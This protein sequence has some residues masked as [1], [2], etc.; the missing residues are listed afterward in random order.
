MKK[1]LLFAAL[2]LT[3]INSQ[4]SAG[5]LPAF[6]FS[7]SA[8]AQTTYR[9]DSIPVGWT[10]T[11]NGIS[12]PVISYG[13]N[14]SQLGYVNAAAGATIGV[15]P[16]AA[17]QVCGVAV[18]KR[19]FVNG[20]E[21][22]AMNDS[23]LFA[24]TNI[25]AN[26]EHQIG[27]YYAWGETTP[28]TNFTWDNYAFGNIPNGTCDR[29]NGNDY[30]VLLPGDDAARAS[31]SAPWRTP[32]TDEWFYSLFNTSFTHT[33]V[34]NYKG[35]GV[36]GLL[37]TCNGG[38]Y[39]GN[40][41]FLPATGAKANTSLD[42]PDEGIY[43]TASL[44]PFDVDYSCYDEA[45]A[46]SFYTNGTDLGSYI[47]TH[48]ER[49]MG[50]PVRAF[51]VDE[52]LA[53]QS[54]TSVAYAGNN[55]WN[56]TMP[57]DGAILRGTE[58]KDP[59]LTWS[60]A[61]ATVYRCPTSNLGSLPRLSAYATSIDLHFGSSDTNVATVNSAGM[62][63]FKDAGTTS[64]YVVHYRNAG[65]GYAYDSAAF[66]L[67]VV[68]L[69]T[70]R[71]V[72]S[73][74][75]RGSVELIAPADSVVSF[76]YGYYWIVPGTKVVVKATPN[77]RCYLSSWSDGTAVNTTGTDT[78][79]VR[80]SMTI[81]A[82]FAAD[83]HQVSVAPNDPTMG[84]AVVTHDGNSYSS[85]TV[86][87]GDSV[88]LVATPVP[89]H[90]FVGWSNGATSDTLVIV[91]TG[92][93]SL[94]AMF[95]KAVP[96]RGDTTVVAYDSLNWNGTTYTESGF[97]YDTLTAAAANGCDSIVTSHLII[98]PPYTLEPRLDSIPIS[99]TVSV[100]GTPVNITPYDA[101]SMLGYVD[102]SEG[103]TVTVVPDDTVGV[104][105]VKVR[106]RIFVNGH[107][108]IAMT[109]SLLFALTNIGADSAHQIGNYYAWGE[110]TPKSTFTWNNYRF[111]N[112]LSGTCTR[113]VGT[114]TLT[115]LPED[116]AAR[117]NWGEP[118]RMPTVDDWNQIFDP[119]WWVYDWERDSNYR[120]SGVM[121]FVCTSRQGDF[122]GNNFFLPASGIYRNNLTGVNDTGACWTASIIDT[123][124]RASQG[125]FAFPVYGY[126]NVDRCIG[127]P[128][129]PVIKSDSLVRLTLHPVEY[130]GN[131]SW[132]FTMPQY[133]VVVNPA[134]CKH[135]GLTWMPTGVT[136]YEGR[137]WI[138]PVL[139]NPAG[140]AVRYGSLNPQV[141][142]IDDT[143][144][145]TLH[146]L[147]SATLY[148]VHYRNSGDGYG[149]D[150][151][152][153][154]LR[155]VPI[156]T[157]TLMASP[158]TNGTVALIEDIF[159][160]GDTIYLDTLTGDYTVK[161][162]DVLT[163]RLSG[164]YQIFADGDLDMMLSGV[165]IDYADADSSY[166]RP[167]LSGDGDVTIY[168]AEGTENYVRG[169]H[170]R[171][172][173]E[174]PFEDQRWQYSGNPG[175]YVDGMLT[176]KGT[177]SLTAVGNGYQAAGIQV[178]Y[179]NDVNLVIE[180]G[181]ITAIGGEK[182]PGIGDAHFLPVGKMIINGGHVVALGG[183][184]GAGIGGGSEAVIGHIMINGGSVLA[185]GG[186]L[187]DGIGVSRYSYYSYCDAV[188]I[189]G[190]ATKVTA[191]AG[192]RN[193]EYYYH[194]SEPTAIML[195][196]R[197]YNSY[198][199]DTVLYDTVVVAGDTLFVTDSLFTY[200]GDGSG[201]L[202]HAAPLQLNDGRYAVARGAEVVAKGMPNE[203]YHVSGW[204]DGTLP[205]SGLDTIDI[206]T[207]KTV[208]VFFEINQ[209]RLDSI[210]AGWTV[211]ADSLPVPVTPYDNINGSMGYVLV[212]ETS[213]VSIMP[214]HPTWVDTL[215]LAVN[216]NG[217]AYVDMGDGLL[218]ATCN[219]GADS[220]YHNGDYY[221]WGELETQYDTLIPLRWKPGIEYYNGYRWPHYRWSSSGGRATRYKGK[222]Y[223]TLRPE[224]DVA[225]H[226][227]GFDW[228]IPT[229]GEWEALSD[230]RN[231]NWSWT[232]NYN[233]TGVSGMVVTSKLEGYQG[234]SI[235]LPSSDSDLLS[236]LNN[237]AGNH[238]FYWSSTL[239]TLPMNHRWDNAGVLYISPEGVK[240]TFALRC[241]G[242]SVRPVVLKPDMATRGT[243]GSWNFT[244]SSIDVHLNVV[245]HQ[246]Y[247]TRVVV[248]D[249]AMGSAQVTYHSISDTSFFVIEGDSALMFASPSNCYHFVGWSNGATTD[250]IIVTPTSD[251]TIVAN[252]E[253]NAPLM[254]DTANIVC[255]SFY[256]HGIVYTASGSYNDTLL[257][258]AT[259]DSVVT[260]NLTVNRSTTSDTSATSCDSLFW[261]GYN[262]T[263]SGS[264]HDTL[265]NAVLCDSIITLQL[266][267]NYSVTTDT[268]NTVCDNF[269]WHGTNYTASGSY[270]D[271]L[272]TVHGCDSVVVLQLTVNYSNTG[273]TTATVCDNLLW[274][275]NSLV[276]SCDT[277]HVLQNVASC[278]STVTL[279]LTVNYQNTGDTNAVEYS[280]FT[281]YEHVGIDSTQQVTH[282][283]AG[284]NQWG[285][286]STVTL[287]LKYPL[288]TT[289]WSGD[290]TVVYNALPQRGITA[291]YVDDAGVLQSPLCIYRRG[292]EQFTAP[293]YPVNAG[294]YTVTAYPLASAPLD[295]LLVDTFTFT[296]MPAT[297]QVV[298]V[299]VEQVKFE[300]GTANVT[301]TDTG[302]LE[303]LQ[304]RYT[305][306]HTV[307]AAYAQ[308]TPGFDIDIT[309]TF[310]LTGDS[311]GNYLL[312]S[313]SRVLHTGVIL[314]RFVTDGEGIV[315][316]PYGYCWGDGTMNYDLLS[317]NPDQYRVD[318][319]DPSFS[320]MDWTDIETPG[321]LVINVPEGAPTGD[322]SA[323]LQ[324]RN[325]NYPNF[326]SDTMTV[327]FHVD[328][329]QA[330][331]QPLFYD[332]IALID[333]CHC[334]TD[335]QWYH[336]GVGETEWVMIPG[337]NDYFYHE[338]GGLTGEYRVRVKIDGVENYSCPQS[339]IY[340][341]LDIDPVAAGE[342]P[343]LK[344]YPN[345]TS[346]TA[347]VEV[348]YSSLFTHRSSLTHSLKVMNVM[349]VELERREFR[350]ERTV[351][352]LSDY[353][354][355]QYI[356]S[357]DGAVI[358]IVR[359]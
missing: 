169:A 87:D 264:Y 187:A 77:D 185:R 331:I 64:I 219:V 223:T 276:A 130:T 347:T 303:G 21:C 246:E 48:M 56:F 88:R 76:V 42:Y 37:I 23:V 242:Q 57:E 148:A 179:D 351:I 65:D 295:S 206:D 90:Y 252:F 338:E 139:E 156:D 354:M 25:G 134:E 8:Q 183:R 108:C 293:D 72:A 122:K 174:R 248:N 306:G 345:P 288:Y 356:V 323:T 26:S 329:P 9:L 337:A 17:T 13:G 118:W 47:E 282:L 133:G 135:P 214:T 196:S 161:Q 204:S 75:T 155:A 152:T 136:I 74:A 226:L 258:A 212:P 265:T 220:I 81:T 80:G 217:H 222:D 234:N 24:L 53:Q 334:M 111:G 194:Y 115:L 302:R 207:C 58:C 62:V 188:T 298:D 181:N 319:A 31:W 277:T 230:T 116:D 29:Y 131:G 330:L 86:G 186:A 238:G 117:M 193:D 225:N 28:K 317:G 33:V 353:P 84:S 120:G 141:A 260:L 165:T 231:F 175:I 128:V 129:R 327:N 157:L 121:G 27:N 145:I 297:V 50:A 68:N 127:L 203:H 215:F 239:G 5:I 257:N 114:D 83:S 229:Y 342:A 160:P 16:S 224:D 235:F 310:T 301:V 124:L 97:Y 170:G 182:A 146:M 40:S 304:G 63:V 66:T 318:F 311:L 159:I 336:R 69:D 343:A 11:V 4:W 290:T 22:I 55:I 71:I 177:G 197:Y 19:I 99:W 173:M 256:W 176:I 60:A 39:K 352:D 191:I 267:V 274:Y 98:I 94:T 349:G 254:G 210:P 250:T 192:S 110:T 292:E 289:L 164:N 309:M 70:L 237:R 216:A 38:A 261:R 357:I 333:T 346:A 213:Q 201:E 275:G 271:S 308:S 67:H 273:D 218:W 59:V 279:H 268:L 12:E 184:H 228:R 259:C 109:D 233:G 30:F 332:L 324:M 138:Q 168:L 348:R 208:T 340:T 245:Q 320:D 283:F 270:S 202:K 180:S 150:S 147:G 6:P 316:D 85:L 112:I 344:V 149:Y 119:G 144:A 167:G 200:L 107:E 284:A 140:V 73:P 36:K 355:G 154:F 296:I 95:E 350:G 7:N 96:A 178:G 287:H 172:F 106:R 151:T 32:T 286:D 92:D 241:N 243:D 312:D 358:R 44:A 322:Y 14:D 299:E 103:A 89:C 278:D 41:I 266:T 269:Y 2:L 272:F 51:F 82:F 209:H 102:I 93:V 291:S 143:G 132:S 100:D 247:L 61:E 166:H 54:L 315:V 35:T 262:Y 300:D 101:L 162:G 78:I 205:D 221:A 305:V 126:V 339:D 1:S 45:E 20:H 198:Y 123:V 142:T 281:W 335:V 199:N 255:D 113:Y 104:C 79:I 211:T 52:T 236:S 341:L 195:S 359:K 253:R 3:T 171:L 307:S 158:D 326:L 314:E 328:L 91:P 285:C 137:E 46:M 190:S 43:W 189:A 105:G 153:L 227:W 325:H 163:G 34:S 280:P 313:T 263:A 294:T 10:V 249:T 240:D 251:T 321:T 244:M 18:R 232:N 49:A 125:V 15:G